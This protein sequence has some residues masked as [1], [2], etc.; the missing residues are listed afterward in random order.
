ML[1]LPARRWILPLTAALLYGLLWLGFR[2]GW[3]DRIDSPTLA[4]AHDYGRNH[5]S[6]VRFWDGF[7]Y[8]F[9]PVTFRVVGMVAAVIALLRRRIRAALLVLVALET[10]GW[11]TAAAKALADRPRPL[12]ALVQAPSSSFPSGHAL[13]VMLGVTVLAAVAGP[14]LHGRAR[15]AAVAVGAVL[16]F[17]VGFARV[18]LN[19]HHPSDVLAGWA[20]GYLWFAVW[21]RLLTPGPAIRSRRR[22]W[23]SSRAR[24]ASACSDT[25]AG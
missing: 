19:V 5:P 3:P 9:A 10:G 21:A 25:A 11:L 8:V 16:V 6:W 1:T 7:S 15:G 13:G 12:T 4:A 17:A 18:A 24:P 20:L 14:A 23:P 2:H 22:R